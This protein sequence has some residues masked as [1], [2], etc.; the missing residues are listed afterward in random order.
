LLPSFPAGSAATSI[1]LWRESVGMHGAF[2]DEE[3]DHGAI[4]VQ[5]TV[6]VLDSDDEPTLA[7]RILQQ[8]HIAYTEAINMCSKENSISS[9]DES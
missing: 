7:A 8:E 3:L 4:I 1:R 9:D 5:K 6:P 2:C